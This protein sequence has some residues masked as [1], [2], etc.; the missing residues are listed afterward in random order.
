MEPKYERDQPPS[1]K[2]GEFEAVLTQW[3]EAEAKLARPRRRSAYRLFEGLQAVG[4][5]GWA[6]FICPRNDDGS[7]H[8]KCGFAHPRTGL[9][10]NTDF[11]ALPN[12]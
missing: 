12:R 7:G 2:L 3:L 1:P 11:L 9:C 4:Y 8:A 10:G 5:G 6:G